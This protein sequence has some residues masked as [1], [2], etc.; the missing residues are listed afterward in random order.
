MLLCDFFVK[1]D[2]LA[3]CC[4]THIFN[5]AFFLENTLNVTAGHTI[6]FLS[7]TCRLIF[8]K[9]SP[10]AAKS[11]MLEKHMLVTGF[12]IV[13]LKS[14]TKTFFFGWRFAWAETS[15]NQFAHPPQKIRQKLP[16]TETGIAQHQKQAYR[17]PRWHMKYKG[18]TY[19]F[20][21]GPSWFEVLFKQCKELKLGVKLPFSNFNQGF[22]GGT[23][24]Y[25]SFTTLY[26]LDLVGFDP[27]F[28]LFYH[29][30]LPRYKRV[31]WCWLAGPAHT[32]KITV[33]QAPIYILVQK[34]TD[35]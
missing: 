10:E 5:D 17:S 12:K 18:D 28:G 15:L 21:K 23:F 4:L 32:K 14:V 8:K 13:I 7:T 22:L 29:S 20:R 31:F 9:T 2:S 24:F 11:S 35:G 30:K 16:C 6:Y 33:F 25:H 1:H 3:H 34:R 27:S 19:I 26:M